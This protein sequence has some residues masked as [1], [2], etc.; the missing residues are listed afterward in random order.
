MSEQNLILASA[1]PRR[2]ELLQTLVPRFDVRTC[3]YAEPEA[4]PAAVSARRWAEALAYFKARAVAES[5]PGN[6][7]LG[8]DTVVTCEEHLL[9]KPRDIADARRMLLLQA[10]RRC[11]VITGVCLVCVNENP[12]RLFGSDV[13]AVWMRDARPEIEAY[14]ESGDWAGKAGAYGIQDSADRLI[15]RTDGSFTNVVGLPLELV[16]QLLQRVRSGA[17]PGGRDAQPGAS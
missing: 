5:S 17:W 1:S 9:G 13:T 10:G 7:V 14:L 12:R 2:R 11:D 16:C 4:K 15:E 6:L 3:P 8:A